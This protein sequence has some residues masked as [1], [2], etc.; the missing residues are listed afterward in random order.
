MVAW[1]AVGIEG[2]PAWRAGALAAW[3][4]EPGFEPVESVRALAVL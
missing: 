4:D 1:G 2:D 3:F